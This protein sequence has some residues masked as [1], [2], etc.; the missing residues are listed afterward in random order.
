MMP[1]R[2]DVA[3]HAALVAQAVHEPRLAEQLVELGAVLLGH[4]GAD[5]GDRVRRRRRPPAP[6]RR[7]RRCGSRAAARRAARA[8]SGRRCRS[9][10]A[11]GSRRGR[12]TPTSPC[13]PRRRARAARRA[14]RPGRRRTRGARA[15]PRPSAIAAMSRSSSSDAPA[16]TGAA[17]RIMPSSSAGGRPVQSPR[18]ARR[19]PTGTIAEP[20][21]R[22]CW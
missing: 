18:C 15:R 13:R 4:L 11:A 20:V 8:R 14:P 16:D 19:S 3:E 10:R 17:P 2:P 12:D 6:V 1:G 9:R 21:K 7:R 22:M 5:A